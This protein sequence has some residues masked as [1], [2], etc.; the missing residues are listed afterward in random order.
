MTI[1]LDYNATAPVRPEVIDKIKEILSLPAN[2]SSVHSYGRMAKKHL[3]DARRIISDHISCWPDEVIFMGSATEANATALGCADK[4]LVS[5]VE[6]SSILRSN[7]V[8]PV[9]TNGIVKLDALEEMLAEQKPTLVSVMLANN[10]TGV[11]QPIA[12]IAKL[13][14]ARNAFLHCDAVQG[15]GKIPVDCG[16]LGV[17][18]LTLSAHKCGGAVGASALIVRR[19]TPFTPLFSGGQ[20]SRRRAGTENVA[21]IAGFAKAIELF[22]FVHMHN[23][24]KWRDVMES[25]ILSK[26]KDLQKAGDSSASPQ[27][28]KIIFGKS[29]QR[30][31]NTTCVSMLGVSHETQ[32]MD[33]D[34]K[35]FAVSAGSACS[36]GRIESSHVLAAMGVPENIAKTAIRISAG[37]NTK[38]EDIKSITSAW[39]S[40]C[41]RL[42]KKIV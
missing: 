30:L 37:W 21:A 38:E 40:T 16:V 20:E 41:E 33:F 27:N 12:E 1:Y 3:E 14:K 13:C 26:A 32:L 4:I 31:P 35:G 9:D 23:V 6:H 5:A 42:A 18:M 11:L 15:L 22:D 24:R 39:L 7:C 36:S 28:D 17:D 34:L 2:A 8:I 10:E 29:A 25:V 19:G